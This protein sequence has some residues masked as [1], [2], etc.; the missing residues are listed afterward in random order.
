MKFDAHT[1]FKDICSKL[2]LTK[3]TYKFTRV[4]SLNNAE[5]ILQNMRRHSN[6]FAIDDTED[7][8]TFKSGAGYF[9]RRTYT[10]YVLKKF[11]ALD[12]GAQHEAIEE[13][14]LIYDK[15]CSKLIHDK[16]KLANEMVYLKDERFAF[17]EIEGIFGDNMTGIFF[18]ITVDVPMD[19]R[20]NINDWE[21]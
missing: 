19:L 10:V 20:Y 6:F 11:K 16:A 9:K 2:K 21:E 4:T 7:G 8:F 3:D 17:K 1:Y 13:A 14:R 5:E 18:M 15:V 12:Q